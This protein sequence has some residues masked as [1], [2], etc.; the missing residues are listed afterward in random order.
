MELKTLILNNCDMGSGELIKH[1]FVKLEE[2]HM[3]EC[4]HFDQ[5]TVIDFIEKNPTLT[6]LS[7]VSNDNWTSAEPIDSI[8]RHLN[9]LVE[10]EIDEEMCHI[11]GTHFQSLGQL[12]ALKILKLNFNT[13]PT[14]PLLKCLVE[15]KVSIEDL[16]V[17]NGYV[18]CEAIKYISQM[19]Q[20]KK[21]ELI[22][23]DGVF[24][25]EHL[26]QL[27]KGLPQ[28]NE[29]RLKEPPNEI[30]SI[31][32]KQMLA[33]AQKLS[34]LQLE[35]VYSITIDVNDYKAML[36]TVKNRPGKVNLLIKITSDGDKV[37]VDETMLAENR[38]ILFIDEEI[39][40][41]SYD[42]TEDSMFEE[43]DWYS[44]DDFWYHDSDADSEDG[45]GYG[46]ING[47]IFSIW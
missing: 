45:H 6:K 19:N 43:D 47:N 40:D 11:D 30:T 23:N 46:L 38:E 25:D 8:G 16:K 9:R 35:S 3:S 39:E 13:L 28:L 33:H 4:Y 20:I 15:N 41:E 12:H 14:I 18:N 7:I 36:K 22:E 31:G 26:I 32:L 27:A 44:D 17:Y 2:A 21:L 34:L 24:T 10:L 1:K 29:L 37:E 42:F 5:D